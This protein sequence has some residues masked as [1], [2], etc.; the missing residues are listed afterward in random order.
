[1][2]KEEEQWEKAEKRLQADHL[3][4]KH[5]NLLEEWEAMQSNLR[6]LR[7][8]LCYDVLDNAARLEIEG[9]VAALVKRKNQLSME[10]GLKFLNFR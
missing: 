9:D 1:M 4:K 3:H 10:L 2:E 5:K 8:Y 6:L 7:Q